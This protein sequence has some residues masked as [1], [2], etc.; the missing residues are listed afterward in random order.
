MRNYAYIDSL[1]DAADNLQYMDYC[2]LLRV[3]WWNM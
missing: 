3:V 1:I 2:R